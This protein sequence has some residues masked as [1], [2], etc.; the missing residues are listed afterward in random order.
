MCCV[1]VWRGSFAEMA[2]GSWKSC[3]RGKES[4][5]IA[6]QRGKLWLNP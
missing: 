1:A 6:S 2:K 5:K 3:T 4:E